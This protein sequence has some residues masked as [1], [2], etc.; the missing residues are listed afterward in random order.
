[1]PY[2]TSLPKHG[3]ERKL[4]SGTH[5]SERSSVF[6]TLIFHAARNRVRDVRALD[7]DQFIA[8]RRRYEKLHRCA[9]RY[10]N[11]GRS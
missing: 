11:R 6:Q 5:A 4:F 2:K 10:F 8:M 1:M 3:S 7:I 9:L